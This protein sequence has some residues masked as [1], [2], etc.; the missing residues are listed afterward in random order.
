M[1]VH[2]PRRVHGG[3]NGRTRSGERWQ[4]THY[5]DFIDLSVLKSRPE[6]WAS[7]RRRVPSISLQ[8][9]LGISRDSTGE[10]RVHI[11]PRSDLI[12]AGKSSFGKRDLARGLCRK[13][14]ESIQN[15]GCW[16]PIGLTRNRIRSNDLKRVLILRILL[17]LST[18]RKRSLFSA[19]IRIKTQPRG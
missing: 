4:R 7:S 14:R 1:S 16:D 5:E 15:R 10:L 9:F 6:K 3:I 17:R 13:Y 2:S 11:A 18:R 19:K 8:P 12:D